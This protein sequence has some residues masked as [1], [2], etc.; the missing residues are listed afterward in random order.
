MIRSG[1]IGI[2]PHRVIGR[3]AFSREIPRPPG[4][5]LRTSGGDGADYP[6]PGLDLVRQ[7]RL[8]IEPELSG[9]IILDRF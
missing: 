3:L 2:R 7:V 1:G 6:K 4:R 9:F 8:A 5:G